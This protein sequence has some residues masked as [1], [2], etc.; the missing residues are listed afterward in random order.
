MESKYK[1]RCSLL[2]HEQDVRAVC[3]AYFPTGGILSASRDL[4]ARVWSPIE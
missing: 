3:A 4:T 2:G 1:I